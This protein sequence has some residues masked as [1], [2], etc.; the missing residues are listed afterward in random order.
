MEVQLTHEEPRAIS[1]S[2]LEATMGLGFRV[3]GLGFRVSGLGFRAG[4][5]FRATRPKRNLGINRVPF[6]ALTG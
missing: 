2:P 1:R 5:G 4:F 6:V 3:S